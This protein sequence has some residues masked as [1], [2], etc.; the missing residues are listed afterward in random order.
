MDIAKTI[1]KNLTALMAPPAAL[2]TCQKLAKRSGVSYGTIQR[3]RNGEINIT[4][5]KLTK[6]AAALKLHPA[7]LLIDKELSGAYALP[8]PLPAPQANEPEAPNIV[9]FTNPKLVELQKIADKLS[10]ARLDQLIGRAAQMAEDYPA[11][12]SGKVASSQ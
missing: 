6:I 9:I 1:G 8:D 4:V 7:E 12:D 10:P 3:I 5:E 2:D 11:D